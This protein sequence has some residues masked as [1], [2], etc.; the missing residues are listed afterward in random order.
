MAKRVTK[1]EAEDAAVH[2]APPPQ[3]AVPPGLPAAAKDGSRRGARP[4]ATDK[5]KATQ[6]HLRITEELKKEFEDAAEREGMELSAWV[7][8][9]LR[10]AAR[11]KTQDAK[12]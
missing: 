3:P 4:K 10:K 8:W 6:I 1:P 9:T 11:A 5:V 12:K 2:P 7:R